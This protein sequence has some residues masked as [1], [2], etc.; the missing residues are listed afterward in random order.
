[1]VTRAP[2]LRAMHGGLVAA[3]ALSGMLA[4]AGCSGSSDDSPAAQTSATQTSAPSEAPNETPTD[5]FTGVPQEFGSPSWPPDRSAS[6]TW[7][8]RPGRC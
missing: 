1:M 4:V 7:T 5:P 8:A 3:A 2:Y 6:P